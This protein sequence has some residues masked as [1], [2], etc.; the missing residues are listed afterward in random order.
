VER[1]KWSWLKELSNGRKMYKASSIDDLI[2]NTDLVKRGRN[3]VAISCD[4]TYIVD[5]IKPTQLIEVYNDISNVVPAVKAR[6]SYFNSDN[7]VDIIINPDLYKREFDNDIFSFNVLS[8][9]FF[10]VNSPVLDS[11]NKVKGMDRRLVLFDYDRIYG[12][13]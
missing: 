2:L 10:Y 9:Y 11:E 12:S 13:K 4:G 7:E 1:V 8:P 3:G 5:R 6:F